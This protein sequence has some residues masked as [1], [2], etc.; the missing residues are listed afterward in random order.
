MSEAEMNA[1]SI[2]VIDQ[3]AFNIWFYAS[4]QSQ[5]GANTNPTGSYPLGQS[6][7]ITLGGTFIKEGD[8]V[9]PVVS[10]VGGIGP[11][12]QAMG[13][14]IRYDPTAGTANYTVS[15]TLFGWS[16]SDPKPG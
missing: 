5:H 3:G 16:I 6:R 13:K 7:T 15:G 11:N 9:A 10:A 8:I 12:S 2:T 14:P 1:S 4:D